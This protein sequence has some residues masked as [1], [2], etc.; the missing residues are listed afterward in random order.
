MDPERLPIVMNRLCAWRVGN[1]HCNFRNS[2]V[3]HA[4]I[5]L[6]A[7]KMSS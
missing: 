5:H 1:F 7:W 6:L 4:N 3:F 2:N